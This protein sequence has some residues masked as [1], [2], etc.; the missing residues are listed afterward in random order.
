MALPPRQGRQDDD[1]V[2]VHGERGHNVLEAAVGLQS[3]DAG[4]NSLD[5]SARVGAL[6]GPVP[7]G[8]ADH[9]LVG[10]DL[11][12]DECRLIG[13]VWRIGLSATAANAR[14]RR[15]VD[16]LQALPRSCEAPQS[17]FS[18]DFFVSSELFSDARKPSI[19]AEGSTC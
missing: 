12:L 13:A 9:K 17:R 3:A 4:Q 14:I 2:A 10:L 7:A 8:T 19:Q 16:L 18:S 1:A 11:D 6:A 15:R 5:S